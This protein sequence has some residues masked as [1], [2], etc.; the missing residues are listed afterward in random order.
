MFVLA[1]KPHKITLIELVSQLVKNPLQCRR[2]WF[3]SWVWNIPWRGDRLFTPTGE[4]N[5][6]P[7]QYSYLEN[8]MNRGTWWATAHGIAK[9]QTGLKRQSL[10]THTQALTPMCIGFP[11]GSDSKELTDNAGDLSLIPGLGRSLGEGMATHFSIFAWRIP[12]DR[13]AWWATIH[14]VT[15]NRTQLSY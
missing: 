8:P 5:G 10:Y 14:G 3:S 4:R 1:M 15:K 9:S 12:M 11:G 7:L 6:N 13:G 2:P